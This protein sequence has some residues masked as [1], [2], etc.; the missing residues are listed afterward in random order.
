MILTSVGIGSGFLLGHFAE[1]PIMAWRAGYL[2]RRHRMQSGLG[3]RRDSA[4]PWNPAMRPLTRRPSSMIIAVCFTNFGPYHLARLR[5]LAARLRGSWRLPDR[6][7]GGRQRADLSVAASA[8]GRAIRLDH[9]VPGSDARD[10]DR[11]GLCPS[12]GPGPRPRSTRCRG[13]RRL[14]PARVNGGSPMGPAKRT[15]LGV[16]VREPGHR[17]AADLVEGVDQTPSAPP[18]RCRPGRR[19]EPSRLSGRAWHARR[20]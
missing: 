13:H 3:A 10:V 14:R 16:D 18:V 9:S 15:S 2:K 12:H 8:A 1:R 17:P 11:F 7:R 6:L 19:T 20:S 5:A 4:D